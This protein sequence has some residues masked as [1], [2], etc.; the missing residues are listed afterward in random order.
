MMDPYYALIE[1]LA[2]EGVLHTKATID[3]FYAIH[4]KEFLPSSL[5]RQAGIDAPL[6]IGYNQTIS[7]P[8]TVA[9]MLELLKPERGQKIMDVGYGSGW[10]SA[11]LAHIVGRKGKV[12]SIEIIPELCAMGKA[13]IAKFNFIKRGIVKTFCQDGS[14]GLASHAPFERILV[15]AQA[16]K[17]PQPWIDQLA[18]GGRL[19]APIGE[20]VW[21]FEKKDKEVKGKEYPGFRF[22]PLTHES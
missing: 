8:Y 5:E 7:Q 1:D 22:V 4:R 9:F 3:A 2:E 13:N 12:Y 18:K 14:R 6:S 10:T 21:C 17:I 19:V 15:S 16:S 11:L 20:S